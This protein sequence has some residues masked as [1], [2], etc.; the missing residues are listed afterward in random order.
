M[1]DSPIANVKL[2]RT[3]KSGESVPLEIEVFQPRRDEIS[4][5][6]EAHISGSHWDKPRHARGSS[7][8]QSL[9]MMM[10][11]L[12]AELEVFEG[13][14]IFSLDSGELEDFSLRSL[15]GW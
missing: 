5:L 6:C 15:F 7:S 10:K 4:W 13:T 9:C 3:N 1:N 11:L 2:L 8:L 14:A 12:R